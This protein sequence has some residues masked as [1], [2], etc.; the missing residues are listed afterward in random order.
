MKARTKE[1][2]QEQPGKRKENNLVGEIYMGVS[3][4]DGADESKKRSG[5]MT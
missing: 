3:T 4:Q 2:G 1:T 5:N